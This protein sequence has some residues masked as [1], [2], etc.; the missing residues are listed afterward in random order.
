M[1]IAKIKNEKINNLVF[2]LDT[3]QSTNDKQACTQKININSIVYDSI[4]KKLKA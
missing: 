2:S 3:L 1:S 4:F